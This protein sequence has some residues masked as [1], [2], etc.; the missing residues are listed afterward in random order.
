MSGLYHSVLSGSAKE[1]RNV[2]AGYGVVLCLTALCMLF[3]A[4]VSQAAG[5]GP[6]PAFINVYKWV[7]VESLGLDSKWM[8]TAGLLFASMILLGIGLTYRA[9]TLKS[10]LLPAGKFGV[11]SL[12]DFGVATAFGVCSD[13][14]GRFKEVLLPFMTSLFL[15]ILTCNLSGLIP[16]FPPPTEDISTNVGFGIAAFFV[17]NWA[18]FKEH[19]MGYV[20]QFLGPIAAMAPLFLLIELI[21][22]AARP[23]SLGVRL[24][25]NILGDHMLVGVFTGLT[26]F[27]VPSFLMFFG[28]MVSC[29]QSYIFTLLTG[30]YVSL[31]I[32]H[33]H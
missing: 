19:G 15:V 2:F 3:S 28:F 16:G 30:I 4:S 5:V 14:C 13:T 7:T 32:S 31:A 18:G 33:D 8:S 1:P 26:Y 21:S 9:E 23:M 17:Y 25:T 10:D 11:R 6:A 12:V 20:K 29:L 27:V 22:H 24:M